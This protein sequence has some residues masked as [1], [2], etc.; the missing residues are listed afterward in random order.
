MRKLSTILILGVVILTI[1][2]ACQGGNPLADTRWQ[3]TLLN[4]M[5]I[6]PDVSVTL[7][8]GEGEIGGSD[9]CNTFGGSYTT[10]DSKLIFGDDVFS[11]MMYCGDEVNAQS[12]AFYQAL[13][14]TAS[15]KME[16]QTLVLLDENGATL[17][18]FSL[19]TN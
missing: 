8:L 18:V 13:A 14:Q 3:L 2:S 4:G 16:N 6:M 7:N 10:S 5:P 1:L 12:T 15:Y 19:P 11:T 17:A 9:G